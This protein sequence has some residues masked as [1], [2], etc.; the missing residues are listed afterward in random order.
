MTN[1]RIIENLET[2]LRQQGITLSC[3]YLELV[4]LHIQSIA[5]GDKEVCETICKFL[6]AIKKYESSKYYNFP[7][8]AHFYDDRSEAYL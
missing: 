7:T 6:V 4:A 3:F 5:E 8:R 1:D 2:H